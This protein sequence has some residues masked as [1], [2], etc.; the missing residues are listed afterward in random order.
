[1]NSIGRQG[2]LLYEDS[3]AHAVLSLPVLPPQADSQ[4]DSANFE[5]FRRAVCESD[6]AA[7]Q[8]V[9]SRYQRLV[10][11]WVRRHPAARLVDPE[12]D[13]VAATFERFWLAVRPDKWH[14]FPDL[15]STLRYLKL[16]AHSAVTDTARRQRAGSTLSL[17]DVSAARAEDPRQSTERSLDELAANELM[18]LVLNA[19]PEKAEQCVARLTLMEGLAPRDIY[20]RHPE[21]FADIAAVYRSKASMLQR[22]RK[23]A[24]LRSALTS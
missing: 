21:L 9:M 22:L 14:Q 17:D 15:A 1:M 20:A 13:W 8:A 11:S 24:T 19:L 7:W 5:L 2:A 10:A 6:N 12:E 23:N 4:E 3:S 16:C 18:N